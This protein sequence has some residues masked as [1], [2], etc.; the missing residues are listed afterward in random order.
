LSALTERAIAVE[1][2]GDDNTADLGDYPEIV[3][4]AIGQRTN[5]ILVAQSLGG[6]TAPLV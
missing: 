6:F 5:V 1:L 4:R 2:P 3:V